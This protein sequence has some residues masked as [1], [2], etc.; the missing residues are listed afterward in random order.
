M[1]FDWEGWLLLAI[2]LCLGVAV[3]VLCFIGGLE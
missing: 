1:K 3:L 2:V